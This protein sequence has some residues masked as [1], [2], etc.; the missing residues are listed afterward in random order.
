MLISWLCRRRPRCDAFIAQPDGDSLRVTYVTRGHLDLE[1]QS[2]LSRTVPECCVWL[3]LYRM[4]FAYLRLLNQAY[5]TCFFLRRLLVLLQSQSSFFQLKKR[6][7]GLFIGAYKVPVEAAVT[8]QMVAFTRN[9][10]GRKESI[11]S[12]K[13][14]V[15]VSVHCSAAP[16]SRLCWD[17][18]LFRNRGHRDTRALSILPGYYRITPNNRKRNLCAALS[19]LIT[20]NNKQR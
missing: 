11:M 8:V 19:R 16:E 3:K 12:T 4:G 15:C 10:N 6:F 17:I 14:L 5:P 9:H 20:R 18:S 2:I 7:T 13:T 1:K